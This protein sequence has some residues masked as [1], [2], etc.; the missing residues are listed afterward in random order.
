MVKSFPCKMENIA[1]MSA[2]LFNI[3]LEVLVSMTIQEKEYWQIMWLSAQAIPMN[4]KNNNNNNNSQNLLELSFLSLE[5][6]ESTHRK[7]QPHVYNTW[8]LKYD[9][10]QSK[11]RKYLLVNLTEHIQG[12]CAEIT[13]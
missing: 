9:F 1:R 2:L 13:K 6:T 3:E 7:N 12:L 8:K 10:N 4:L 11:E 5:Y